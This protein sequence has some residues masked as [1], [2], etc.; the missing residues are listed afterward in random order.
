MRNRQP[1][2]AKSNNNQN[3]AFHSS[4]ISYKLNDMPSA[5]QEIVSGATKFNN[6]SK[7]NSN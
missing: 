2:S 7:Q 1:N 4:S 6:N 3:Q 5:D